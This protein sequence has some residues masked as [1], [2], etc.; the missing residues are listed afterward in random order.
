MLW[1]YV[2]KACGFVVAYKVSIHVDETDSSRPL[3]ISHLPPIHGSESTKVPRAIQ[4]LR[5]I[6]FSPYFPLLSF[7]VFLC[8]FFCFTKILKLFAEVMN[9]KDLRYE[10]YT[11][12]IRTYFLRTLRSLKVRNHCFV[13][14]VAIHFYIS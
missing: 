10:C 2:R 8:E 7:S 4:V 6:P 13:M 11:Y 14:K 12:A 9:T 3:Q 5:L 1:Y